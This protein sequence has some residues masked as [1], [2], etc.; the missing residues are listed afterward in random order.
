MLVVAASPHLFMIGIAVRY[1]E[2]YMH[3]KSINLCMKQ[4]RHYLRIFQAIQDMTGLGTE[5]RKEMESPRI[6]LLL[7]TF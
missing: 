3:N 7:V 1:L 5:R 6:I 4:I 2:I